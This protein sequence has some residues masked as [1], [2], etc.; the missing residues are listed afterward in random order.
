MAH[1]LLVPASRIGLAL[2][3]VTLP[4]PDRPGKSKASAPLGQGIW[5]VVSPF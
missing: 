4:G 5:R 2:T 1:N 3:P